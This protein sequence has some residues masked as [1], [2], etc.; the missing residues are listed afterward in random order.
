MCEQNAKQ[1]VWNGALVAEYRLS[2]AHD[3]VLDNVTSEFYSS[4]FNAS[5]LLTPCS[6]LHA[7]H[8]SS[9]SR[10]PPPQD[11][12]QSMTKQGT[13]LTHPLIPLILYFL[14]PWQLAYSWRFDEFTLVSYGCQASYIAPDNQQIAVLCIAIPR[15]ARPP[16]KAIENISN[17]GSWLNCHGWQHAETSTPARCAPAP[18][19]GLF[20]SPPRRGPAVQDTLLH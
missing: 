15:H 8:S 2:A 20:V 16:H 10:F 19:L 1:R 5:H 14:K 17:R 9:E 11:T 18:L 6:R 4:L 13:A 3:R 12:Y 7:A